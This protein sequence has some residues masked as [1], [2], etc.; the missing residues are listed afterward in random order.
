MAVCC[1][2]VRVVRGPDWEWGDQDGGEGYVGT[3]V[4]VESSSHS[5]ESSPDVAVVQWDAGERY[6]YRCGAQGKYDLRVLDSGAAG[7][8][9]GTRGLVCR[10]ARM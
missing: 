2:G 6:T 7:N 1:A 5:P 4:L 8:G 3:V 9:A 10:V